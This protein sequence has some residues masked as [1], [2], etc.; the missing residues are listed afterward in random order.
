M[1]EVFLLGACFSERVF[2]VPAFFPAFLVP[3][4]LVV[5]FFAETARLAVVFFLA[6]PVSPPEVRFAAVFFLFVFF[7]FEVAF[8]VPAFSL[9][10]DFF[11]AGLLTVVERSPFFLRTARRPRLAGAET[12]S[13]DA[14]PVSMS[15]PKTDDSSSDA[16][17]LPLRDLLPGTG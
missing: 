2:S 15:T 3:H 8:L 14:S 9:A 17:T 4:L 1:E 5:G 10:D 16:S 6:C 12:S 7:L 13:A 11:A